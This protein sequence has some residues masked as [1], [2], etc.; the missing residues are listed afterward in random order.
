MAVPT[1]VNVNPLHSNA[2]GGQV[3]TIVGTNFRPYVSPAYGYLGGTAPNYAEVLFGS[4]LARDVKVIS[5]TQIE[6]TA[7]PFAGELEVD[8]VDYPAVSLSVTNLDDNL[9]PI[10]GEIAT[11]AAIFIYKHDA[12]RPPEQDRAPVTERLARGLIRMFKREILRN[13]G[14][15]VN[16]DFADAGQVKQLAKLPSLFM[17]GPAMRRDDYGEE[18]FEPYKVEQDGSVL[19]WRRPSMYTAS[20]E[21]TL[22]SD[23]VMEALALI[24]AVQSSWRRNPYFV[25]Q[26][27]VPDSSMLEMPLVITADFTPGATEGESNLVAFSA[28][29]EV[30]RIPVLH[31]PPYARTKVVDTLQI[32]VQKMDGILVETIQV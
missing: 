7:P 10:A 17:S 32:G 29:F 27:D 9:S 20:F 18:N 3:I 6:C 2:G 26:A 23:K 13:T 14:I 12:I 4:E 5:S 24:D 21:L 22:L 8:T 30:Q 28:S 15:R 19:L 31:L 1:I 11:T 16:T 25:L